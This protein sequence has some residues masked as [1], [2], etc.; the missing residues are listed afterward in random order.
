MR[1]LPCLLLAA[2]T[3]LLTGCGGGLRAD[4]EPVVVSAIGGTM[5][6]GDP[7]GG[8]VNFPG[9]VLNGATARGLVRFDPAGQVEPG[10]AERW[11]VIDDGRSYIFRLR[12]ATWADGEPVTAAQVVRALRRAIAP[13]SRNPLAP[14]LA[15]IDE[16]VE[17]TPQVIEVRLKR[18]RPDLL[19]L[20]A[21]PELA[22]FRPGT[23]VGSGPFAAQSGPGGSMMLRLLPDPLRPRPDDA[24]E[25]QPLRLHGERAAVAL[26]RFQA[27]RSDLVLGGTFAD[28]P[29]VAQAGVNAANIRTDP[30]T[31]LF[32][33]AV[34]R[35]DGFLADPANRAA[36]A[37][38]IDRAALTA[39]V[40][41]D[42]APAETL[43]PEQFDSAAPPATPAWTAL[44]L[45][46]RRAAAIG[47]VQ[48]WVRAQGGSP[49]LRIALPAGPGATLVWGYLAASL[50]RVGIL[51]QRVG[52]DAE[53]ELRLVDAV[54]PYDSGRWFVQTACQPCS[55]TAAERVA[56]G[57]DASDL[58]SR[59][60]RIAE[61]D[62]ALAADTAFIPLARPLRWSL[63][64]VRLDAWQRNTRAWHP[65]NHLRNETE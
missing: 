36:V 52:P 12:A 51:T 62:A 50:R 13:A 24:P 37:M 30:A 42:W 53:A 63:V 55:E 57:R 3:L 22:I 34:V 31:G 58:P 26:A 9:R 40:M 23:R 35:R 27:R 65:L 18:P 38:A 21:Q 59:A 8:P 1:A 7:N 10:L 61:A 41:P 25:E 44:T 2:A 16:V 60:Q 32:G 4:G 47:R 17:M 5:E 39:A 14:F 33:L 56:A 11:I 43:L 46:A 45:E 20:F 48:A 19:R 28:W 49:T 54:A 6:R 29:L 15:V 64:A